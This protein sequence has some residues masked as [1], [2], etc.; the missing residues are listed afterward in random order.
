MIRMGSITVCLPE[1]QPIIDRI[2]QTNG[3]E[4]IVIIANNNQMLDSI[5]LS[6]TA[7]PVI[8][9]I[10]KENFCYDSKTC[11]KSL[12]SFDFEN[13]ALS[14]AKL[15]ANKNLFIWSKI[16]T[17]QCYNCIENMVK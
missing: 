13:T 9:F 6:N 5:I 3:C 7:I 17:I 8:N 12:M 15:L 11:I 16:K 1:F 14:V 10:R 2:N 4:V